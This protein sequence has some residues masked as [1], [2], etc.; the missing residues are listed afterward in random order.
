MRV[1]Q[2]SE[3][4]L[5]YFT[6]VFVLCQVVRA[7]FCGGKLPAKCNHLYA[8]P[9]RRGRRFLL[10]GKVHHTFFV[11]APVIFRRSRVPPPYWVFVGWPHTIKCSV[12][13]G[14][15]RSGALVA[16]AATIFRKAFGSPSRGAAAEGD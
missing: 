15:D 16:D 2:P 3:R 14:L 4:L 7:I 6:R 5:E 11:S 8:H 1:E 9:G 10:W 12:G 13:N